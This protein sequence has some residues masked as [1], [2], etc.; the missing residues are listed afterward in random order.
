MSSKSGSRRFRRLSHVRLSFSALDD[1]TYR[2]RAAQ[3]TEYHREITFYSA[4]RI[5]YAVAL[6][7]NRPKES[8]ERLVVEHTESEELSEKQF[9]DI[10]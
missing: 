10:A 6:A 3:L 7:V 2:L 8:F 5:E 4:A 1:R 9:N